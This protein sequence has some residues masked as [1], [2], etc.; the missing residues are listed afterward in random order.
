MFKRY[1]ISVE[2]ELANAMQV[3]EAYHAAQTA[4]QAQSNVRTMAASK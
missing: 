4:K 1:N 3:T 2:A